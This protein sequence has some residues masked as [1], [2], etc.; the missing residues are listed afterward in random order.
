VFLALLWGFWNYRTKLVVKTSSKTMM[1]TMMGGAL[2]AM[3]GNFALVVQLSPSSTCIVALSVPF[4][5]LL[6]LPAGASCLVYSWTTGCGWALYFGSYILKSYRIKL[7]FSE[8]TA[9][10]FYFFVEKFFFIHLFSLQENIAKARKETS[11][12]LTSSC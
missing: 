12:L 2:L 7:I 11:S 5:F 6:F 3:T 10:G 9:Q 1:Y 8:E 4:F